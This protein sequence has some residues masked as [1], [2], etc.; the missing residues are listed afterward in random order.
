MTR[1]RSH[2][3]VGGVL[4]VAQ[5]VE[6]VG[7]LAIGVRQRDGRGDGAAAGGEDRHAGI[8]QAV[9]AVHGVQAAAALG[10]QRP[11][12]KLIAAGIVLSE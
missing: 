12:E 1:R 8:Q 2:R 3:R 7:A 6:G 4:P 10:L 9:H 11:L 5:A